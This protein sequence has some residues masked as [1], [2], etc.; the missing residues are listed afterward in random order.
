VLTKNNDDGECDTLLNGWILEEDASSR[1]Y[2]F[3]CD[4]LSK[5][6]IVRTCIHIEKNEIKNSRKITRAS[7]DSMGPVFTDGR[8]KST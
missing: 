3:I 4:G 2:G 1:H 5:T 6:R 8:F 7:R